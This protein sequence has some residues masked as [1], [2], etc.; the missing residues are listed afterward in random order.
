[1][2]LADRNEHIK[3]QFE[4]WTS[5][6]LGSSRLHMEV[7]APLNE[8]GVGSDLPTSPHDQI[9]HSTRDVSD[10]GTVGLKMHLKRC[11]KW[12]RGQTT[13]RSWASRS[14]CACAAATTR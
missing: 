8:D 3:W 6:S 4:Q 1:M 11:Q 12:C 7:T 5:E 14:W 13:V 10:L 2:L 9:V